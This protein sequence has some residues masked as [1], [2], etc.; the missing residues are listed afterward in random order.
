MLVV[1]LTVTA[2]IKKADASMVA[3]HNSAKEKAYSEMSI[4]FLR[5]SPQKMLYFGE[6]LCPGERFYILEHTLHTRSSVKYG[7][8]KTTSQEEYL[9]EGYYQIGSIFMTKESLMGHPHYLDLLSEYGRDGWSSSLPTMNKLLTN[10]EGQKP[11]YLL[12]NNVLYE[13]KSEETGTI[14]YVQ[15]VEK[16]MP[17][18]SYEYH[19][20][21][22]SGKEIRLLYNHNNSLRGYDDITER[23]ASLTDAITGDYVPIKSSH[24]RCVDFAVKD[25][26][27][28]GY[29]SVQMV[30]VLDNNG[31]RLALR[32]KDVQSYDFGIVYQTNHD[33]VYLMTE[34]T[35]KKMLIAEDNL[36]KESEA[37]YRKA[38]L[39]RKQELISKYGESFGTLIS[40]GKVALGMSKEMVMAAW[41]FPEAAID[42]KNAIGEVTVWGYGLNNYI[43]FAGGTV[44]SITQGY[45]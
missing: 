35:Y 29:G 14:Y 38:E 32:I 8:F 41:G 2:Q 11:P 12:R 26:Y 20:G 25:D 39:E 13:V 17:V 4:Q 16:A 37:A 1:P 22:L 44:S 23:K 34:D 42:H 36:R 15:N 21:D 6:T 40:E 30:V 24:Y 9:P 33:D 18:R 10:L 45:Y 5:F 27:G 31:N 7:T 43:T 3:G 19:S 28:T